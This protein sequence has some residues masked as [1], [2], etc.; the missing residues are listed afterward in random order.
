MSMVTLRGW[1][2]GPVLG[3]GLGF[4]KLYREYRFMVRIRSCVQCECKGEI[5]VQG[6]S[7]VCVMSMVTVRG[8][9]RD[10]GLG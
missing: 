2:Q 8:G 9:F 3:L 10:Q 7:D 1:F 6:Y 5:E 4:G